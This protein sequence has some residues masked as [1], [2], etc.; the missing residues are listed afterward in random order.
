MEVEAVN[1]GGGKGSMEV[2]AARGGRGKVS[3][4][5]GGGPAAGIN[6]LH[7][8]DGCQTRQKKSTP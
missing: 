4:Q 2:E 3:G 7:A 6:E 5:T 8:R 1:V